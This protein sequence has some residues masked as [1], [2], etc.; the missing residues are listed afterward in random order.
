MPILR[1]PLPL[2][3]PSPFVLRSRRT[4]SGG[5]CLDSVIGWNLRGLVLWWGNGGGWT[6][7]A[8][9]EIVYLS[10][11]GLVPSTKSMGDV[12][13]AKLAAL[14][15]P[16][17]KSVLVSL[18]RRPW[19]SGVLRVSWGDLFGKLQFVRGTNESLRPREKVAAQPTDEGKIPCRITPHHP[20]RGSFSPRR[21]LAFIFL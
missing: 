9:Y 17:A 14:A 11:W 10:W 3:D 1:D 21:S 8:L 4:G 16:K 19:I 2:K 13:L 12:L 5:V 7:F 18:D 6:G 20:L 15:E